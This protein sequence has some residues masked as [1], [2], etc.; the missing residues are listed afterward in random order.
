MTENL[1]QDVRSL[2]FP[3]TDAA[4]LLTTR[5]KR[6]GN[7]PP[8]DTHVLQEDK[9]DFHHFLVAKL[10]AEIRELSPEIGISRI[11]KQ[12]GIVP[13]Q[14]HFRDPKAAKPPCGRGVVL[15]MCRGVK[16]C[17]FNHTYRCTNEEAK[18]V[19]KMIEDVPNKL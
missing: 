4:G 7:K 6:G 11:C 5:T 9:Q 12:A 2:F 14:L 13:A 19:L 18:N 3:T 16:S 10:V 1:I 17:N 15:G 8:P